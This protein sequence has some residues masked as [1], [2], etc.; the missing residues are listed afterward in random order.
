MS[1]SG[2]RSNSISS[3]SEQ[4]A[5]RYRET[6]CG[7]QSSRPARSW[8]RAA[9]SEFVGRCLQL[10]IAALLARGTE[11]IPL[12][13]EHLQQRAPL[14]IERLG[15]AFHHLPGNSSCGAGSHVS[16]VHRH[17]AQLARAMRLEFRVITKMRNPRTLLFSRLNDGLPVTE[18]NVIS[19]QRKRRAHGCSSSKC[20]E[21]CAPSSS[22]PVIRRAGANARSRSKAG[23]KAAFDRRRS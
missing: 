3:S 15:I 21:R 16:S 5:R 18:G 4:S 10:A 13:E 1:V 23:S 17:R 20:T 12:Y 11:M 19:I 22:R 2:E 6:T 7:S 8:P 9:S 14:A